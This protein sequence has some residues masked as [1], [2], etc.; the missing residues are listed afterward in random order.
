M[1]SK[2]T[3]HCHYDNNQ[4]YVIWTYHTSPSSTS[5]VAHTGADWAHGGVLDI[6]GS[7]LYR[8]Q[9]LSQ[10]IVPR[11]LKCKYQH[12]LQVSLTS[13]KYAGDRSFHKAAPILY[14]ALPVTIKQLLL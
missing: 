3:E 13:L 9:F 6:Q 8:T 5:L 14:N 4:Y 1:H 10:K 11:Q 7:S 2:N 12:L